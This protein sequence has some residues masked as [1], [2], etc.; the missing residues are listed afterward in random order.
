MVRPRL[1]ALDRLRGL[2]VAAMTLANNPGN[3]NRVYPALQRLLAPLEW[4]GL[5]PPAI[6]FLSELTARAVHYPWGHG[7]APTDAVFW[8]VLVPLIDDHG[9]PRSSLVYAC[10]SGP[11]SPGSCAGRAFASASEPDPPSR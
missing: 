10:C 5:N 7:L 1:G 3:W 8:T 4:L 9:E 2:T 11:A 6:Y